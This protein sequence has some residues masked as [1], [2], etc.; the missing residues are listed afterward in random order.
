MNESVVLVL[1]DY[2]NNKG[3]VFRVFSDEIMYMILYDHIIKIEIENQ[4]IK[5]DGI[6]LVSADNKKF[7]ISKSVAFT[8]TKIGDMIDLGYCE[9]GGGIPTN[10]RGDILS[11]IIEYMKYESEHS[12]KLCAEDRTIREWD[13]NFFKVPRSQIFELLLGS[14]Y[15]DVPALTESLCKK[16]ANMIRAGEFREEIR[17]ELRKEI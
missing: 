12:T 9:D 14:N 5:R 2:E 6:I 7:E 1:L 8:S 13:V 17:K 11:K 4:R 16:L 10:V 15:L 3:S